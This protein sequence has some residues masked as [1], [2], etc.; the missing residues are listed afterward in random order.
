MTSTADGHGELSLA[1]INGRVL[2]ARRELPRA[3]AVG[4]RGAEIVAVGTSEDVRAAVPG[5]E[6]VDTAGRTVLPGLID[7]HNHFLATGES[8]ATIDVRYPEVGSV[9]ELVAAIAAAASRAQARRARRLPARLRLRPRQVR[10]DPRPAGTWTAQ[11]PRHPVLVG[12]VSGHYVLANSLALAA[13]RRHRTPRPT[14]P[15]GGSTGTS[16]D[17]PLACSATRRWG[18]STRPPWTSAIMGRTSTSPPNPGELVAAVERAGR[19]YVAAGLTTVCDAQVTSRELRAYRD[20]RSRRPAAGADG[21]HAP[22]TPAQA[23]IQ[24]IG[25]GGPVR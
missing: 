23:T 9:D 5:A 15:A 11:R 4:I 14:R 6:V 25:H 12:H 20:A 3:E 1:I 21:V 17:G 8:L 24:A 22:V 2:T 10:T 13:Q 18:W 19:A 7:A 16:R